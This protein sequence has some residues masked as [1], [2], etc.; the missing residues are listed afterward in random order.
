MAQITDSI[1]EQLKEE[2]KFFQNYDVPLQHQTQ[3]IATKEKNLDPF[4]K[5]NWKNI[6]DAEDGYHSKKD[7]SGNLLWAY[8]IK[9]SKGKRGL[10]D[11]ADDVVGNIQ[12]G[13]LQVTRFAYKE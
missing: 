10:K 7:D 6:Y 13:D 9:T 3:P 2:A 12:I 4:K 8:F 11:F 5:V 1:K